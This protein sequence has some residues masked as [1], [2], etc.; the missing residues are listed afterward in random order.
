[1]K[2]RPYTTREEIANAVTHGAG[3]IGGLVG[4][5]LLLVVAACAGAMAVLGAWV[6]AVSLILMYGASTLYRS[7]TPKVSWSALL[8]WLEAHVKNLMPKKK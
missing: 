1:M 6:F 5:K 3:V 4:A 2:S 8:S 7:A